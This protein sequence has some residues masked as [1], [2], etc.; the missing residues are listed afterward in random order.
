M[1]AL[2]T[3][4]P[5]L[6]WGPAGRSGVANKCLPLELTGLDLPE[7]QLILACPPLSSLTLCFILAV[8]GLK[9]AVIFYVICLIYWFFF[10]LL[11]SL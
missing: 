7:M 5:T 9:S 8:L 1:L 10:L 11:L 3:L 4:L 6:P 2:P